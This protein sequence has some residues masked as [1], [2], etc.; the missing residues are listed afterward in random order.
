MVFIE[1]SVFTRQVLALLSDDEYAALQAELARDP[2]AGD[3][4]EG[5]GGL[6]KLRVAAKGKG[7]RGGARVI[8]FFV[9]AAMQCRMLLIYPKGAKDDLTAA[10]RKQLRRLIEDWK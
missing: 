7:T 8:Y 4:I 3:V 5:T 2:H 10:E 1:T 6:R 9:D